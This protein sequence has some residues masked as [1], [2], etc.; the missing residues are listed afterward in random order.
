VPVVVDDVVAAVSVDVCAVV[1]LK[2]SDVGDKLQVAA[3]VALVGV[4]VTE[5]ARATVP[6][7][8][9]PGV[10]VMVEVP[11]PPGAM[12]MLALLESV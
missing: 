11:L 10:T 12:L 9:L 3:L 5:Q 1:L 2:V 6:V 4:L 7:N 8:E